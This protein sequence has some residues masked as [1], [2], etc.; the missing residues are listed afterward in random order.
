MGGVLAAAGVDIVAE[1]RLAEAA[2]FIELSTSAGPG[3]IKSGQEER[4][5]RGRG[6]AGA[7]LSRRDRSYGCGSSGR[8]RKQTGA[9]PPPGGGRRPKSVVRTA[10]AE[11]LWLDEV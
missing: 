7:Q 11:T 6:A 4:P 1:S 2:Q 3:R 5:S 8:E 9:G 10:R